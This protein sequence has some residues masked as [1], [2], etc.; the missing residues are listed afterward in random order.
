MTQEMFVLITALQK[1]SYV[2]L[3]L[4][5]PFSHSLQNLTFF[6]ASSVHYVPFT[7]K[8]SGTGR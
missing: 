5:F 8:K 7:S 6:E 1:N 2:N 3:D 4:T